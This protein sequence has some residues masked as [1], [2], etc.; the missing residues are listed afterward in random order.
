M[1]FCWWASRRS[2]MTRRCRVI[3]FSSRPTF[4]SSRMPF[5]NSLRLRST[6][7]TLYPVTRFYLLAKSFISFIK[8]RTLVS[9]ANARISDG[10]RHVSSSSSAKER[11][12]FELINYVIRSSYDM[13]SRLADSLRTFIFVGDLLTCI[14]KDYLAADLSVIERPS[15]L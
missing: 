9:I 13:A 8:S 2:L 3:C 14:S 12:F 15:T 10:S 5:W 4:I 1:K 6:T 7:S 11:C